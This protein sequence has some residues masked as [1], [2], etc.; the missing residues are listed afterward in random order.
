MPSDLQTSVVL[1]SSR[2]PGINRFGTGFVIRQTPDA[3]ILVTCAHVIDDVGGPGNVDVE[4]QAGEVV[5]LGAA[6][7]LDMAVVRIPAQPGKP[8]LELHSSGQT[9]SDIRTAG[10]QLFANRYLLRPLNGKLG[11]MVTLAVRGRADRVAAWDLLI[12]GD[13]KRQPGYSGS[14]VVDR[15]GG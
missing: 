5:A 13:Y 1:I 11:E 10:Y 3:T 9:G 6:D 7:E 14:P 2:D 15:S 12:E 4:G 8:A